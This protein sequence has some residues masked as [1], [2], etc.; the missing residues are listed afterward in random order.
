MPATTEHGT[1][2]APLH[3]RLP[4][5]SH[6]FSPGQQQSQATRFVG[7]LLPGAAQLATLG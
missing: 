3:A 6:L 4:C 2:Y 7:S 5:G 1:L